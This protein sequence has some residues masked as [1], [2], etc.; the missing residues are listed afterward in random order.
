MDFTNFNFLLFFLP[1]FILTFIFIRTE[2]KI[3]FIILASLVFL[4]IGNKLSIPYLITIGFIG[5]LIALIIAGETQLKKRR[6]FLAAGILINLALLVG[7][8]TISTRADLT[9]APPV[10]SG[11]LVSLIVPVGLSYVTLQIISYLVDVYR[12]NTPA[13]K[14]ILSFFAYILF[15]PKLVSGPLIRYQPFK[16]EL[17]KNAPADFEAIAA[18]LRRILIG[19]CKRILLANQLAIV[20][21]AAFNLPTANISP[22]YAWLALLAYALQIYFDFS[23]YTDIALGAAQ[24]I[25]IRLP[26]NFNNPYLAQSIGDFWRRWHISLSNWF[27]EYVFYP[28]ERHRFKF[29]GQKIN[30]L[31]IFILTGAWHGLTLNFLIWGL[32]HGIA[33]AFESSG[34]SRWLKS[35]WKPFQHFYALGLVIFS[36]IFFRSSTPGFALE[37]IGRL[38]G[39]HTGLTIA[40]FSLTRPFPFIEPSFILVLLAG[41]ILCLPL[42]ALQEKC[43]SYLYSWLGNKYGDLFLIVSKDACLIVLLIVAFAAQLSGG[44]YPNIYAQF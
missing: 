10:I 23:G 38:F 8:K 36:W 24:M 33:I 4:Y 20:A 11:I 6:F 28:L 12:G 26:E 39:N 35:L 15:F 13:E 16:N 5:Y 42:H 40:P 22:L 21:N 44:Y 37:F 32:I 17:N 14:N 25:G 30:L 18:G 7:L 3:H 1:I 9:H 43:R 27:R 29:F 31:L 19:V 41:I 2:L 34:G